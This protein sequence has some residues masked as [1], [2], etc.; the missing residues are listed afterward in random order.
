MG[1]PGS[2]LLGQEPV[3]TCF[4]VDIPLG[5]EMAGGECGSME[6]NMKTQT[7]IYLFKKK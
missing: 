4:S 5:T 1:L 2:C 6:E 7:Y 3:D